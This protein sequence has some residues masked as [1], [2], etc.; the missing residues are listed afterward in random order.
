M[1]KEIK[2]GMMKYGII[3][4]I[5]KDLYTD[6]EGMLRR[7]T[8]A[9]PAGR[10]VYLSRYINEDGVLC[11]GLNR[12]KS[13]YTKSN[14]PWN[15]IENVRCTKI[16]NTRALWLMVDYGEYPDMWWTHKKEDETRSK[17]FAE[18]LN[19]ILAGNTDLLTKHLEEREKQF[20][21]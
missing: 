4:N 13:R 21:C 15:M 3:A 7:G 5:K 20:Y 6:E 2:P 10:K 18:L 16:F 1:Y 19:Q 9:F 14:V 8:K 11:L 17:D 12:F